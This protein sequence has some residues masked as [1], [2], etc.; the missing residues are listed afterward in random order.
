MKI[1]ALPA[2]LL[3]CF[4]SHAAEAPEQVHDKSLAEATALA[5]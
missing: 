3:I 5:N 1:F 4:G 2:L